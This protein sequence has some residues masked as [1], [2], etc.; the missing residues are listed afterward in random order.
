MNE[1]DYFGPNWQHHFNPGWIAPWPAGMRR[2]KLDDFWDSLELDIQLSGDFRWVCLERDRD[3]FERWRAPR[4]DFR[5]YG[6][7][8]PLREVEREVMRLAAE[9]VDRFGYDFC[10]RFID[11]VLAD[12]DDG[13]H[14]WLIANVERRFGRKGLLLFGGWLSVHI[15][16]RDQWLGSS[17][18][19]EAGC[20]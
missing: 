10:Q 11:A 8:R 15:T 12:K 1:R 19:E 16:G 18:V 9:T 4:I 6:R 5:S 17:S 13:E 20:A 3:D 14:G 7:K 2:R